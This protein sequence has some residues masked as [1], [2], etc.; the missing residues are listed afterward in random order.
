MVAPRMPDG[1][2][3]LPKLGRWCSRPFRVERSLCGMQDGAIEGTEVMCGIKE[4]G[5][6]MIKSMPKTAEEEC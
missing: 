6:Q 3:L 2:E 1:R 4:A 5:E